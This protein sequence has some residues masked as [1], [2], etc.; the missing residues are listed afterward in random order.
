[1]IG[2]TLPPSS[3]LRLPVCPLDGAPA[4]VTASTPMRPDTFQRM[5]GFSPHRYWLTDGRRDRVLPTKRWPRRDLIFARATRRIGRTSSSPRPEDVGL[6]GTNWESVGVK[7]QVGVPASQA[8]IAAHKAALE[9]ILNTGLDG[10]SARDTKAALRR[11]SADLESPARSPSRA[12][13][14]DG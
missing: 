4:A 10:E 13:R 14:T 8:L 6:G 1:M 12:N 3:V 5:C 11:V 2:T 7:P 9:H